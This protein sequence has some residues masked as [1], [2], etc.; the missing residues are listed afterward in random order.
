MI[1]EDS[2]KEKHKDNLRQG[3]LEWMITFPKDLDCD[4]QR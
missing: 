1:T 4:K 2:V 3:G